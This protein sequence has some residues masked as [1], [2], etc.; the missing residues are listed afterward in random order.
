MT[1]SMNDAPISSRYMP[2]GSVKE[3]AK[4]S[5]HG[6]WNRSALAVFV[7]GI[8]SSGV[9]SIP[10][11]GWIIS[12]AVSGPLTLGITVFFLNIS[13]KRSSRIEDL[14]CGFKD[15]KRSC[16]TNLLMILY[17]V[18]WS[19]LF[20]IPGIIATLSYSLIFYILADNPE[21]SSCDAISR[22]KELMQGH[23]TELLLLYL[24]FIG[25]GLLCL[26]SFGI[27]FFWLAP[28]TNTSVAHFYR[29]II[30]DDDKTEVSTPGVY[31][32]D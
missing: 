21:I 29:K 5:L 28:Y 22:S 10:A 16:I 17:V 23:K 32:Y 2:S 6:Q 18:L 7:F 11:L 13:R 26:L 4:A 9:Y 8:L 19:I 25:W 1:E 27:G 30:D 14:L 24:S 3:K 15:F 20:I 31:I 12:L